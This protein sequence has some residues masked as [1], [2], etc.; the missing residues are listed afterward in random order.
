MPLVGV[1]AALV[2]LPT[3]GFSVPGVSDLVEG[4]GIGLVVDPS[5]GIEG[6]A[7]AAIGLLDPGR[8]F[9]ADPAFVDATDP[10]RVA[11]RLALAYRRITER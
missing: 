11:E 8:A 5:D 7:R 10:E 6:L 2:G 3:L 4:S 9:V 1:E